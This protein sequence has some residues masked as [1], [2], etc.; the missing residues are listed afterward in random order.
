MSD[1]LDRLKTLLGGASGGEIPRRAVICR[2]G[3]IAERASYPDL[4]EVVA[5]SA[6]CDIVRK[7]Y[8][9][10]THPR[11]PAILFRECIDSNHPSAWQA[12]YMDIR[13]GDI[14]GTDVRGF[15]QDNTRDAVGLITA[16]VTSRD[17]AH[18]LGVLC[19]IAATVPE[20]SDDT[21]YAIAGAFSMNLSVCVDSFARHGRS[22]PSKYRD[23]LM[24][25]LGK[26][27]SLAGVSSNTT[28]TLLRDALQESPGK[29]DLLMRAMIHAPLEG[30]RTICPDIVEKII[31]RTEVAPLAKRYPPLV[32]LTRIFRD[33][34]EALQEFEASVGDIVAKT[35]AELSKVGTSLDAR[36]ALAC[37]MLA[38][39][40]LARDPPGGLSEKLAA[41]LAATLEQCTA[42]LVRL[43]ASG[44]T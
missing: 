4:P 10:P 22:L 1:T 9:L 16:L 25:A 7:S 27:L 43:A 15:F 42:A 23:S 37:A 11:D 40:V 38:R 41:P 3:R 33:D 8:G 12:L 20:V 30:S 19:A 14:Q 24:T 35:L 39:R 32:L 31:R 44:S 13:T 36:A 2:D 21:R 5:V 29:A 28:I 34:P 17:S 18:T 26:L 6:M